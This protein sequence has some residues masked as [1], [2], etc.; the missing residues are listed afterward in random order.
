MS[1]WMFILHR[2]H[3]VNVT[4][5]ISYLTRP[6]LHAGLPPS[7][8]SVTHT[9]RTT[10]GTSPVSV[11]WN[12]QMFSWLEKVCC[13]MH[14]ALRSTSALVQSQ[15]SGFVLKCFPWNCAQTWTDLQRMN[16]H[17]SQSL[18]LVPDRMPA[19]LILFNNSIQ[20]HFKYLY[21]S[22]QRSHG[23]LFYFSPNQLKLINGTTWQMMITLIS[24]LVSVRAWNWEMIRENVQAP[25]C[26]LNESKWTPHH[27]LYDLFSLK[28]VWQWIR[29][30]KNRHI[31]NTDLNQ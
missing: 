29:R 23:P 1:L 13:F 19:Q 9:L 21:Q 12:S 16:L 10:C 20:Y 17:G 15:I 26:F 22:L 14:T 4:L 5:T 6:M 18:T 3:C 11:P 8:C 24:C 27:P 30:A 31:S 7:Y 25:L 2:P 28:W